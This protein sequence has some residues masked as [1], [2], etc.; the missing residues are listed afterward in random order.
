MSFFFPTLHSSKTFTITNRTSQL[1]VL[2][3]SERILM[4]LL[5]SMTENVHSFLCTCRT[6]W[7]F[8]SQV[9]VRALWLCHMDLRIQQRRPIPISFSLKSFSEKVNG[10]RI[11]YMAMDMGFATWGLSDHLADHGI[12]IPAQRPE[13]EKTLK[14]TMRLLG[15]RA[16]PETLSIALANHMMAHVGVFVSSAWSKGHTEYA[17]MGMRL[18]FDCLKHDPQ[19]WHLEVSL[20]DLFWMDV[21]LFHWLIMV[22]VPAD[23][24]STIRHIQ[25][26]VVQLRWRPIL[27]K[28]IHCFS[29][30]IAEYL[31]VDGLWDCEKELNG[32][33]L[34]ALID[35]RHSI[36]FLE[37]LIMHGLD[38]EKEHERVYRE[39]K[40]VHQGLFAQRIRE[41]GYE[42]SHTDSRP[43]LKYNP[44]REMWKEIDAKLQLRESL[45]RQ[46]SVLDLNR[47]E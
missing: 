10:R 29:F 23:D 41:L 15:A 9:H 6:L 31:I 22:I 14:R 18:Y 35:S 3:K 46:S 2:L 21:E 38:L 40:R 39:A 37:F 25:E 20:S 26:Q 44:A 43:R 30:L 33:V 27:P 7:E 36:A 24:A 4:T 34:E 28:V 19:S 13:S 8:G 11:I 42:D 12:M 1:P 32:T 17:L 16:R 5:L 47:K 45:S